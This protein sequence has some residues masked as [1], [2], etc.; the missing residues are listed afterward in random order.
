MKLKIMSGAYSLNSEISVD[1]IVLLK[2]YNPDSLCIKD[3]EGNVKFA[4]GYSEGHP[5]VS[6]FGVTFGTKSLTNGKASVTEIL[7]L[8]LDTVEK[9]KDY[10]AEKFGGVVAYLEALEA[11]IP[12]VARFIREQKQT[13]I[14]SITVA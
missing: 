13:L 9:A 3:D 10:L 4:I 11:S 8:D 14:D 6:T 2:K 7:P 5:C 1:D 12:N